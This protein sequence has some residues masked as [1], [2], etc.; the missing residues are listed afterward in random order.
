MSRLLFNTAKRL[1]PRISETELIALRSGTVSIDREI[2]S[3]HVDMQKLFK[4]DN[5]RTSYLKNE[6]EDICKKLQHE[7][8][9]DGKINLKVLDNLNKKKA[10][11]YIIK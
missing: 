6:L 10:F 8:V 1:L 9:F 2:M 11:S 5:K 3:G 7:S 4:L